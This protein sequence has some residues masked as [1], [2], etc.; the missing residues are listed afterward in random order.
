MTLRT[1]K[2][3]SRHTRGCLRDWRMERARHRP[4]S[5]CPIYSQWASTIIRRCIT[6][7]TLAISSSR[8]SAPV[9]HCAF[10][11]GSSMVRSIRRKGNRRGLYHIRIG[12]NGTPA[13]PV[14]P[15]RTLMRVFFS[16]TCHGDV[17]LLGFDVQ[18]LIVNAHM[19]RTSYHMSTVYQARQDC[20]GAMSFPLI[21]ADAYPCSS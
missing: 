6:P 20:D 2:A 11:R 1:S 15:A 13:L 14:K 8:L 4:E 19:Q 10:G 17:R 5:A 7:A 3:R 21:Q 16:R 18:A 9:T 12:K